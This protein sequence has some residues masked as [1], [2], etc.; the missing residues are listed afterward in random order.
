M[1][2]EW[3]LLV[4]TTVATLIIALL[5]IRWL[6]PGLLGIP[7]DLQMV[8]VEKKLPPFFEGVFREEDQKSDLFILKDP[9]S[10]IRAHPL[11]YEQG[12]IGPHDILGFRNRSVPNIADLI[13]IGDSQT[14][15]VNVPLDFNWPSTTRK[16]LRDKLLTLYNMSVGGWSALQYYYIFKHALYLNPRA[17]VVA[18][19]TGNDPTESFT[20]AYGSETWSEFRVDPSLHKS[21]APKAEFPPPPDDEWKVTFR[22]GITTVFAPKLRLTSNL[23]VPAVKAGYTILAKAAEQMSS[24]AKPFNIPVAFTIIPTKELVYAEKVR[25][26]NIDAPQEYI[27]LVRNEKKYINWLRDKILSP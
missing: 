3:V 1:K 23:E 2:K 19:Y 9:I 13:T 24:I 14:Y 10:N 4:A 25:I 6:A 18:F 21:D 20:L 26:E 12:I 7:V 16:I 27:E 5:V 17:V 11:I 15:G 8:R 22:D